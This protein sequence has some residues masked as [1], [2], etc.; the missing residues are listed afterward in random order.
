[1]KP[2]LFDFDNMEILNLKLRC[3]LIRNLII[4]LA[5]NKVS[6]RCVGWEEGGRLRGTKVIDCSVLA[7]L[8]KPTS[9][10]HPA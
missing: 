2:V 5:D 10:M 1:M 3:Y 9:V 4:R 8:R 7:R 6:A